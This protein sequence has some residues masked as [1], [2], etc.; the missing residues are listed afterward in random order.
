[1]SG[2]CDNGFIFIGRNARWSDFAPRAWFNFSDVS[3]I[4][5]YLGTGRVRMPHHR[6]RIGIN[7]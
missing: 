7:R 5:Q 1:M 2:S 6:P 3:N 4:D